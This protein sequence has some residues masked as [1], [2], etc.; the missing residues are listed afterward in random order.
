MLHTVVFIGRSGCGKGTQAA[1]LKERIIARDPNKRQL[2]YVETGAQFRQ[3]FHGETFTQRLAKE[4]YEADERQPNFLGSYMWCETLIQEL[5]DDMHLFLDGVARAR[6]EAEL[7]TT[8]FEFYKRERPT[9]V[10]LNVSRKWSEERLLAR[11]REDDRTL[12]KITKRLDWFE[13]DTLPAIEYFKQ[14]RFYRFLDINGEQSIEK[15]QE[16]IISA[17][18][19]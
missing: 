10:Y 6:A 19:A 4:V 7:L 13:S 14:M 2:L 15:V 3:F 17:Y 8:A 16:D 9:I 12:G 5:G 1:L 18:E 11:G